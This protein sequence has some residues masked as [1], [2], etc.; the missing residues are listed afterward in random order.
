[1]EN[2]GVA[3]LRRGFPKHENADMGIK[4]PFLDDTTL[5]FG[6]KAVTLTLSFYRLQTAS[7]NRFFYLVPIAFL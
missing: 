5:Q 2:A 7:N 6:T 1:L 4:M 3:L